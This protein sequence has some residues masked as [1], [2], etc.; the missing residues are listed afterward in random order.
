VQDV[1]PTPE[2]FRRLARSAPYRWSTLLFEGTWGARVEPHRVRV[3][4]PDRV[5]AETLTGAVLFDG[6]QGSAPST[7]VLTCDGS[8]HP[9]QPA[10]ARSGARRRRLVVGERQ[11]WNDGPEVPFWQDYRFVAVLDPYELSAGVEV[12]DVAAVDHAGRPAWEAVLRP[13][14]AYEPRCACCPLMRSRDTDLMEGLVPLP[15]YADE[16]RIRLDVGTGVCVLSREVG[17]PA[18]GQGHDL[19]LLH[20]T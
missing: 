19:A 1:D 9:H 20:V 11:P 2:R 15:A 5:R 7:A 17:G 13:T 12:V 4:R 8:H 6:R 14:P 18:D 10:G 16:H 3:E